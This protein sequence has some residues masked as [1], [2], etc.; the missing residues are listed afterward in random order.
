MGTVL[1]VIALI[2]L[3]VFL[4]G[5]VLNFLAKPPART[6]MIIGLA[7]WAVA[8]VIGLFDSLF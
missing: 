1:A 5:V 4:V 3:I 2:G 6:V 8:S 7:I